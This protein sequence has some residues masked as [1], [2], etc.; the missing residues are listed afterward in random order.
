MRHE[1]TEKKDTGFHHYYGAIMD[2]VSHPLGVTIPNLKK[3]NF[4]IDSTQ[5]I[6][7]QNLVC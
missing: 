6:M 5:T 7:C 2:D 3:K 4:V 1:K